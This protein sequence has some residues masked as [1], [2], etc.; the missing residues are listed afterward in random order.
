MHASIGC[1]CNAFC[2][3]AR[4]GARAPHQQSDSSPKARSPQCGYAES[5]IFH[6]PPLYYF[7]DLTDAYALAVSC[8]ALWAAVPP[9]LRVRVV[10]IGSGPHVGDPISVREYH[11]TPTYGER[12]VAPS[13]GFVVH[14]AQ[15]GG[16]RHAEFLCLLNTELTDGDTA[17][18]D[19]VA[20]VLQCIDRGAHDDDRRRTKATLPPR[21][22]SIQ[23]ARRKKKAECAIARSDS[24]VLRRLYV[25]KMTRAHVP[26]VGPSIRSVVLGP[27]T[28]FSVVLELLTLA[29]HFPS[30]RSVSHDSSRL[31]ACTLTTAVQKFAAAVAHREKVC[32]MPAPPLRYN[33]NSGAELAVSDFRCGI[34]HTMLFR[35]VDTFAAIACEY[36]HP[37][38]ARR[39]F[40]KGSPVE[41]LC[42]LDE[43]SVWL[44]CPNACHAQYVTQLIAPQSDQDGITKGMSYLVNCNPW[45]VYF[46]PSNTTEWE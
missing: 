40:L 35:H 20:T 41:A 7:L 43:T 37:G 5:I 6:A 33:A 18:H 8:T 13:K 22:D 23:F 24:S 45:M 36:Y 30:L 1:D 39:V 26:Y 32:D 42:P 12:A 16:L 38:P 34:C 21:G 28:H 29:G 31:S 11:G 15:N 46:N 19:W 3:S 17:R 44:L 4:C 25:A 9:L 14:C 27:D 10:Q 2:R